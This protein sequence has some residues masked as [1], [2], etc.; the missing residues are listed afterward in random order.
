LV[1]WP[2]TLPP[3]LAAGTASI[4]ATEDTI[5]TNVDAGV[6]KMRRRYTA[7]PAIFTSDIQLNQTQVLAL[8]A[9]YG[10]TLGSVGL[11]NWTDYSTGLAAT[12]GFTQRPTYRHAPN[13]GGT[14]ILWLATIVLER[15]P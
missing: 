3:P 10:T 6:P 7:A 5:R 11:F 9:F 12:Y 13:T 4:K 1:N 2:T 8:E 15:Q 14:Q